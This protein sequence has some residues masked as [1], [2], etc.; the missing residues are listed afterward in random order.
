MVC[1]LALIQELKLK[2]F[3]AKK[4]PFLGD[5]VATDITKRVLEKVKK[6]VGHDKE[7]IRKEL[8]KQE[9]GIPMWQRLL[10]EELRKE[11]KKKN[12]KVK[13]VKIKNV[14]EEYI[15]EEIVSR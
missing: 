10:I 14:D 8:L 13:K 12:K 7:K 15:V 1:F 4:E 2:D 9:H 5:K 6:K 11:K 3:L